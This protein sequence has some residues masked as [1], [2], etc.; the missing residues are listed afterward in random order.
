MPEWLR[1]LTLI[2]LGYVL[3]AIEIL[4]IPGFGILGISGIVS[5]ILASYFAYTKLSLWLGLI[6]SLGSVLLIILSWKL[7]PKSGF[8][9]KL[10]LEEQETKEAGFKS[11][12]GDL[13]ELIN[14]EG[15][16]LSHLRPVGICLIDGKRME[17][18]SEGG[19]FI[20][21]DKPIMVVKVEGNRIVVREMAR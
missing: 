19:I 4:I 1:V 6:V 18:I 16:T 8:W 14:K 13:S 5:L 11:F 17:A 10:R 3:L 9:K 20:E 2:L 15:R 7:F 21:Q 12:K